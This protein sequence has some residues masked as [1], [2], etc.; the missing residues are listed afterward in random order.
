MEERS[1]ADACIEQREARRCAKRD[2][3][4]LESLDITA[5]LNR[6]KKHKRGA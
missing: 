6:K 4:Y 3:A 1:I 5:F 2:R